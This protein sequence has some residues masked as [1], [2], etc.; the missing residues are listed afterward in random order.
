[1]QQAVQHNFAGVC[2][3]PFWVKKA[4]RDLKD[5]PVALVTV[6]GFPLG[7]QM[8][9]TK[10]AEIKQAL[11]DG[12]DEVDVVMNVSALKSQ[13]PWVKI[14]IAKYAQLVHEQ[15][16]MLKVILE[17]AYLNEQELTL[18]CKY[19]A[20]AGA[21]FAKTSTGFAPEG[22]QVATVALMRQ[23][24]PEQVGIKASGG[25]RTLEQVHEFVKAGAERIGTSA[26]VQI[27]EQARSNS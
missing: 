27:M 23:L 3:P 16:K 17:T 19:V 1:V 4:R 7:Y 12:A 8:S 25:I 2:V 15:G 26:G 11:K 5:A 18:A 13:M 21:D 10:E 24:L 22:A 6:A 14:E 20:D 9:Q